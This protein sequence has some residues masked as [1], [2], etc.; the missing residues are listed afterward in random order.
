MGCVL[1]LLDEPGSSIWKLTVK[2]GP[3]TF[4]TVYVYTCISVF[5]PVKYI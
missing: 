1:Q 4:Y 3:C 2:I 5:V